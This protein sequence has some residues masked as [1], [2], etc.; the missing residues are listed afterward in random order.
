MPGDDSVERAESTAHGRTAAI[1]SRDVVGAEPAREHHA[2]LGRAGALEV[3]RVVFAPR[4]VDDRADALA[5][6]Q[7]RR[8]ARAVPVLARVELHEVG[9]R[10]VLLADEDGDAEHRVGRVEQ[11]VGRGAGSRAARMKP[12]RSAPASTATSTSSCR[13]SPQTLTSGRCTSSRS[14]APGSA[15]R[16]SVEPTSTAFAP[17]SS[18]AAACARVS[19]PLSAI[20]TRSRGARATSS[21]CAA[22]SIANVAEVARVDPDD[23]RVERDRARELVRV[24]RL[25]ERVEPERVGRAHQLARRARRR[26]RAGCSSAASAPASRASRRCSG[27]EKKPLASSGSVGGRARR[28]QV[29]PRAVEALVD[30]HRHRARARRAA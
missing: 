22:R 30:E 2:S 25:D 24:V 29:V 3:R 10:L 23:R 1:A 4:Q 11:R 15:A 21:S 14:F 9:V 7:Q 16:I 17:A 12:T 27:V 20:T 6:P 26:G 5:A 18:A 28:A 19:M 13:V 8:V